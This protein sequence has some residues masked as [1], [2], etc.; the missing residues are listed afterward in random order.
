MSLCAA[1]RRASI[2]STHNTLNT[3]QPCSQQAHSSHGTQNSLANM[4]RPSRRLLKLTLP[5]L[6]ALPALLISSPPSP[7]VGRMAYAMLLIAAYWA[8]EALPI[9]ATALLPLVLFPVLGIMTADDVASAFFKDKNVLFFGGLVIAAALEAV[10]AHERI[11]LKTLLLFGMQPRRLLLGFMAATAFLSMW[12]NNTATCAMMMPIADAVLSHLSASAARIGGA[13]SDPA[14]GGVD[15]AGTRASSTLAPPLPDRCDRES[16]QDGA[17]HLEGL[18]KALALGVAW[19]ANIGGMATLTGTGPNI[20]LAGQF[21]S[22][23]PAAPALSFASWTVYAAPIAIATLAIAHSLLCARFL[24]R[25]A[26]GLYDVEATTRLIHAQ[27]SSLGPPTYREAAVLADFVALATLWVTRSPGFMPGWGVLFGDRVTDATSAIAMALLLFA[28]PSEK[29][30]V[31]ALCSHAPSSVSRSASDLVTRARSLVLD[32]T[33]RGRATE[34]RTV[35]MMLDESPAISSANHLECSGTMA[36]AAAVRTEL[37][38]DRVRK[39]VT[40]QRGYDGQLSA[41]PSATSRRAGGEPDALISWKEVQSRLP[42]GVLILLG[43]GFAL[44]DGCRASGLSQL[45]GEEL[46]V[47]SSLPLGI[48]VGLLTLFTAAATAVTSN[49]ATASIFLPIV[50]GLADNMGV[51]PFALMLPVTLTTSLAFALPVSTPPNAL[52]F[53]SGRLRVLDMAPL[54]TLLTLVSIAVVLGGTAS[55]GSVI[56]GL[57][58]LPSWALP[59]VTMSGEGGT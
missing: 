3:T 49:V 38:G 32:R 42:W 16:A 15:E 53:A 37:P 50:A 35:H 6:L 29:P 18:G 25:S 55:L 56:F 7:L 39:R 20:V 54:G 33:S 5:P 57:D 22:L 41:S 1:R 24:V 46:E 12:M 28:L 11:A 14:A 51:H 45:L 8:T 48:V 17:E 40:N 21:N 19:S 59:N 9:A 4:A 26:E 44:A 10:R 2:L 34:L 31:L 23:Y 36:A 13:A 30:A 47:V 43:G 52:A 58:E 27:H